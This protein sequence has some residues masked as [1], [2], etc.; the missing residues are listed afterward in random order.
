MCLT[1]PI[2]QQPLVSD[3]SVRPPG[4]AHTLCVLRKSYLLRE[5]TADQVVSGLK[6]KLKTS[7]TKVRLVSLKKIWKQAGRSHERCD[8]DFAENADFAGFDLRNRTQLNGHSNTYKRGFPLACS[9]PYFNDVRITEMP[10]KSCQK[11]KKIVITSRRVGKVWKVPNSSASLVSVAQPKFPSVP[12]PCPFDLLDL[13][14]KGLGKLPAILEIVRSMDRFDRSFHRFSHWPSLA[15]PATRWIVL[16]SLSGL[17][18]VGFCERRQSWAVLK[19]SQ[20][21]TSS[22]TPS[23]IKQ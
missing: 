17:Q 2:R 7:P 21:L 16:T 22:W 20:W 11:S 15:C 1:K 23:A 8:V 18:H 14:E 12:G 5:K 4:A 13:R 6:L 19:K 9:M 3:S 10:K